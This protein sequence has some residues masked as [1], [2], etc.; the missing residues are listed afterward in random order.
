MDEQ[1]NGRRNRRTEEQKN[2]RMKGRTN[3]RKNEEQTKDRIHR[4]VLKLG[5]TKLA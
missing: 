5:L 3:E 4:F 1:T 2:K